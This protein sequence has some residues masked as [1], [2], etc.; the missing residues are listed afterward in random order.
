TGEGVEWCD[1]VL[2]D[3][4]DGTQTT[5]GICGRSITPGGVFHFERKVD[6]WRNAALG[7]LFNPVYFNYGIAV[8]GSSNVPSSPVSHGCVRI[9]M[10]LAEYFPSLVQDG[11]LV[12][13][14][15]GVE[16]PE[17]YGAQL[18]TFDY[19]DPNFETS[20]SSTSSTVEPTTTFVSAGT[21][22]ASTVP[23]TTHEH[24]QPTPIA[25][26]TT[27]PPTSVTVGGETS[28]STVG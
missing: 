1:Q 25:P 22:T 24:V 17:I 16:E 2:M 6:G 3:N 12:Y 8:H 11:D 4:D 20:T 28:T 18:P 19:A 5:Q 9:P 7:R 14:F 21:Q 15:D 27:I 13:V 26:A 23:P 10:H